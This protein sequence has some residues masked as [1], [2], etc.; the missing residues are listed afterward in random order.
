MTRFA[1]LPLTFF[2]LLATP[3]GGEAAQRQAAP[4][5]AAQEPS[6]PQQSARETR[7]DLQRLLEQYGPALPRVLKLDPTLL[8]NDAY[9][10]P[11]PA[12][13]QF[14]AQHPDI[15]RNPTY[16]FNDYNTGIW[17][18]RPRLP[19]DRAYEMW[20]KMLDGFTIFFVFAS[21]FGGVIWLIR[22]GIEHR[23]WLRLSKIQTEVHN[24]LLDRFSANEDLLAYIQ[25]PAGKRF[26]ESAPIPLDNPRAIAA[27]FSRI[28]WSAQIGAILT[29]GGIGIEIVASRAVEEVAQPLAA[30]GVFV[31]AIG[32]GFLVSSAL[33]YVISRRMGLLAPAE[34][35]IE[36]RG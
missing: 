27:P 13:R 20:N 10:Q 7:D 8:T 25:T 15:A 5:A 17:E 9:L 35:V 19:Q 34:P 3:Q 2:L 1:A 11:Y 14:L 30:V 23:R 29:V 32:L 21:I 26:L 4:A 24:K 22:T 6:V 33:A 18:D 31:I 16:Y 36:S 28:L 12:L